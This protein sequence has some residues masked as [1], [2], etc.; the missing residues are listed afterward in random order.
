MSDSFSAGSLAHNPWLRHRSCFTKSSFPTR[1]AA[2]A[3][4]TQ[5]EG[6]VYA[7]FI[8]MGFHLTKNQNPRAAWRL[9]PGFLGADYRTIAQDDD[10]DE[11][12]PY[13]TSGKTEHAPM[14]G[15]R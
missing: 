2:R 8:C 1:E 13:S 12:V 9:P 7:C 15:S 3:V 14:P 5:F 11:V 10:S 6:A 4:A